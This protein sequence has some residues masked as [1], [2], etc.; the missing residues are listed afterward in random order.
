MILQLKDVP[1]GAVCYTQ[2]RIG[3]D[4]N[5]M[6]VREVF[7]IRDPDAP[8]RYSHNVRI[9]RIGIAQGDEAG[10]NL[11]AMPRYH[12]FSVPCRD[13]G[14]VDGRINVHLL[15]AGRSTWMHKFV[16]Y[17]YTK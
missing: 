16:E 7:Y 14:E 5:A 12:R 2:E 13:P 3:D 9:G 4:K 17:L 1:A 11:N 15:S 10:A 8:C 6:E